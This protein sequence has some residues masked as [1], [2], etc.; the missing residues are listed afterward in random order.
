MFALYHINAQIDNFQIN[1]TLTGN[2]GNFSS[3]VTAPN[4]NGVANISKT[5]GG[6]FD[7]PHLR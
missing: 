2:I 5:I 4:F 3:T 6:A 1:Q 7:I